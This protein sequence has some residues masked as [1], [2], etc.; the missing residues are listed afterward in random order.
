VPARWLGDIGRDDLFALAG[1]SEDPVSPEGRLAVEH[2][3][4][5]LRDA[6]AAAILRWDIGCLAATRAAIEAGRR[7]VGPE[8]GY[9]VFRGRAQPGFHDRRLAAAA[10]LWPQPRVAAWLR[11]WVEPRKVPGAFHPCPEVWRVYLDGDGPVAASLVHAGATVSPVG[12]AASGCA[13]AVSAGWRLFGRLREERVLDRLQR[14]GERP[15]GILCTLDV[16][17]DGA[18]RALLLDGG[19]APAGSR[20][21][22]SWRCGFPPGAALAGIALGDGVVLPMIGRAEPAAVIA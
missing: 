1:Q 17:I 3:A 22:T 6:P 12:L 2:L 7:P 21:R 15:D 13:A 9:S 11:P 8:R 4:E 10:L 20:G 18:G 5:A 14:D 19:A 16:L